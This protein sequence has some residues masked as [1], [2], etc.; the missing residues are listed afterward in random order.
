VFFFAG[1]PA[2]KTLRDVDRWNALIAACPTHAHWLDGEPISD[3]LP[4]GGVTDRYRRFVVDG[5]PVATGVLAVGDAWACTNPVGGRGITIGL[6]HA[7]GTAEVVRDH[8]DDPLSLAFAHD[9]MTEARVTPWYQSTV[10]FD[11]LRTA[12]I[13]AAIQGRPAPRPSGPAEALPI[14]MMHDATLFRAF[15]EINALLALPQEVMARPGIVDR[16]MSIADIQE[17]VPLPGP[18]RPELLRMLA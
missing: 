3:V 12:Q 15:L 7:V 2:L 6:M 1:D 9:A 4:M 16:I 17:P 10:A 5:S 18:S 14:A 13:K 11:R 8:L